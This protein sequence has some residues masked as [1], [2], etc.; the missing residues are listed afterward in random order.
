M[1]VIEILFFLLRAIHDFSFF[2]PTLHQPEYV[3][4]YTYESPEAGDLTFEEG[5]V[6]VVTEREGEWWRGC[7]G[8]HAGLFPSNYVRPVELEVSQDPSIRPSLSLKL[9]S[10]YHHVFLCHL[11]ISFLRNCSY[12]RPELQL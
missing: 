3:A 7:I 9:P 5:D 11:Y 8:D 12:R 6:V 2:P 1:L 4:L 10:N